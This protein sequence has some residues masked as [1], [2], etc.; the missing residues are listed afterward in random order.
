MAPPEGVVACADASR[1]TVIEFVTTKP[2]E[3]RCRNHNF[4]LVPVLDGACGWHSAAGCFLLL[5]LPICAVIFID[6]LL[7]LTAGSFPSLFEPISF[8]HSLARYRV[9]ET[10]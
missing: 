9:A 6:T 4:V 5:T 7:A 3:H 8:V 10:E 1:R 2:S